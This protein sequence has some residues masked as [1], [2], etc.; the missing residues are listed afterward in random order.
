MIVCTLIIL[1]SMMVSGDYADFGDYDPRASLKLSLFSLRLI[2][3][4]VT[5]LT[6]DHLIMMLFSPLGHCY[7]LV[8]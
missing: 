4:I 7:R 3:M 6:S 2:V 8:S 5:V 1:V